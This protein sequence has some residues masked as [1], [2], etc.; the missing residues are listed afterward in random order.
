MLSHLRGNCENFK[1]IGMDASVLDYYLPEERI[2]RYPAKRRDESRLLVFDRKTQRISH[3]IFKDIAFFLPPHCNIFRNDAAVLKGRIFAEKTSGAKVECLLLAPSGGD[4]IW[5]CMLKPGR[6]LPE[7]AK[8]GIPGVFEA[9][10]LKK[11]SDGSAL[12]S[13]TLEKF[14]GLV[15]MSENFGVVPLPPYIARRQDSPE[16]D[17]TFDNIRYE[18]VYAD[19]KKR[20]AAAAPTAGL[21]FTKELEDSLVRAGHDFRQ[22]T[23][24]IGI[25]TFQPLKADKV[26]DHHMHSERY[27]IPAETLRA[28]ADT[29][30]PRVAVGTT[31][32]RAMEDYCRKHPK[33]D[34]STDASDSASLF[35]Y[36]PQRVVSAD[37]AITNFHL[38]RST[39]MCLIAAFLAPDSESGIDLLKSIYA[40]A[41]SL[42]YNFYSYGDA[43][44]IL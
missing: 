24:N 41:I 13:F 1:E 23:L 27:F 4:M 2:A 36:P 34:F 31:S 12:V 39:L 14:G 19:P 26:Q 9:E 35:V 16:Y 15:E 32:L 25:G 3:A 38:P 20:V 8:F 28:M 10:V 6:R 42:K 17:K 21:H 33:I 18:T 29:S 30:R 40:E 37:I 43:M 11:N 22:L 44:L 7:G 5:S